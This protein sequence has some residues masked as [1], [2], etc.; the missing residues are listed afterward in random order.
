MPNFINIDLAVSLQIRQKKTA[1]KP[2]DRHQ[3]RKLRIRV[4]LIED[5]QST[6]TD[7]GECCIDEVEEFTYLENVVS[8]ITGVRVAISLT[9]WDGTDDCFA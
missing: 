9:D 4:V 8:S 5:R 2:V 7:V 3:V 1:A 6:E